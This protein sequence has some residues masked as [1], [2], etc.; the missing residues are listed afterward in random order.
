MAN[1]YRNRLLSGEKMNELNG[2]LNLYHKLVKKLEDEKKVTFESLIDIL[3]EVFIDGKNAEEKGVIVYFE[4]DN[5]GST[6]NAKLFHSNNG[7]NYQQICRFLKKITAFYCFGEILYIEN[8][9]KL[10]G[11][12]INMMPDHILFQEENCT[13][14]LDK[15]SIASGH[16]YIDVN[17]ADYDIR[18]NKNMQSVNT[19]KNGENVEKIQDG[20]R[21]FN[22]I[23]DGGTHD[24][25][26]CDIAKYIATVKYKNIFI[27]TNSTLLCCRLCDDRLYCSNCGNN[28]AYHCDRTNNENIVLQRKVARMPGIVKF[29]AGPM[30]TL[31]EC[32][33]DGINCEYTHELYIHKSDRYLLFEWIKSHGED[34]IKFFTIIVASMLII[35]DDSNS[36]L[37]Y[38]ATIIGVSFLIAFLMCQYDYYIEYTFSEKFVVDDINR[39]KYSKFY[40][41]MAMVHYDDNFLY[42]GISNK[43]RKVNENKNTNEIDNNAPQHAVAISINSENKN[44]EQPNENKTQQAKLLTDEKTSENVGQ[45]DTDALRQIKLSTFT[46]INDQFEFIKLRNFQL[47]PCSNNAKNTTDCDMICTKWSVLI[48]LMLFSL[49][50]VT[51]FILQDIYGMWSDVEHWLLLISKIATF[52][53]LSSKISEF[54]ESCHMFSFGKLPEKTNENIKKYMDKVHRRTIPE[55]PQPV[56]GLF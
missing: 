21:N 10:V 31:A 32:K 44:A 30:A 53:W 48:I 46:E 47:C 55:S 16:V 25:R 24:L 2:T 41:R 29:D 56:N 3:N 19:T 36:T 17:N 28:H 37:A 1:I 9:W 33:H 22:P 52:V 26:D 50:T 8:K 39:K 15:Y 23:K 43:R 42:K 11:E 4:N 51:T 18:Y 7:Y 40:T 34:L 27:S 12:I 13:Y 14:K 49:A 35:C 6:E 5:A 54:N 20:V 45:I 38:Y